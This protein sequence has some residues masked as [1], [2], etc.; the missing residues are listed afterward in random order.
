MDIDVAALAAELLQAGREQC[1]VPRLTHRF[2]GL[3]LARAYAVQQ[4]L[5]ALRLSAG[6]RLVGHKIGL[7]SQA[8]QRLLGVDEPDFGFLVRSMLLPDG[9][10]VALSELIQPK[11][12]AEV[13]FVLAADLEGPGVGVQDVLR[14]TAGVV[15][16]L[17]I[18]DSRIANWE[19]RLPDTVADN[20]SSARVVLGSTLSAVTGLDLRLVGMVLEVNGEVVQ[21]AAGAAVLGHPARAVAWL[22]NRLAEF[23]E[24]LRAGAVVLSGALGAAI[25]PGPGDHFRASFDRLGSVEVSF[26]Q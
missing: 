8:M 19:L 6:E 10:R 16:A 5:R 24:G 18:I 1:P 13:A 2:P 11:V 14:A 20:A 7:T 25:A 15:P 23:G 26:G 4:Q 12:E 3:D 9:G 22:A 17:E 21:T